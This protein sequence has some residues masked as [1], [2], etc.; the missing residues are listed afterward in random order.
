VR[1]EFLLE[2][3]FQFL[4][5]ILLQFLFELLF[6]MGLHSIG[7]TLRKPRHPVW[8]TV[9][10]SLWGAMAGGLSLLILSNLVIADPELRLANMFVTPVFAGL[11]M[12]LVGRLREKR[13]QALLRIDRFA[14]AFA[15][16]FAMAAVRFVWGARW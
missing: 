2:P 7:H 6:E 16:A 12:M 5:E 8:A 13:G 9:G 10:Y 1:V 3:I 11:L 15:F 4:G 14:Y